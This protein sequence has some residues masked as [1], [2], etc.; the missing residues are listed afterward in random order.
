MLN[1]QNL[2]GLKIKGIQ[3]NRS[4]M[5][6]FISKWH[7]TLYELNPPLQHGDLNLQVEEV[8]TM[9]RPPQSCQ[10]LLIGLSAIQNKIQ[11]LIV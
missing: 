6:R 2:V 5:S 9:T 11:N 10:K 8:C 7:I 3:Q 4:N 1:A